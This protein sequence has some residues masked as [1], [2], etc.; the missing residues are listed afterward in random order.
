MYKDKDKDKDKGKSKG[1]V[2][3]RVKDR[4]RGRGR[5]RGRDRGRIRAAP[6]AVGEGKLQLVRCNH[7][8]VEVLAV[9]Q[10]VLRGTE[11]SVHADLERVGGGGWELARV[12]RAYEGA[13]GGGCTR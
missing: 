11:Q 10:R 5:G 12:G 8:P 6:L 13:G 1:R 2:G 3:G 9:E 4:G 7:R